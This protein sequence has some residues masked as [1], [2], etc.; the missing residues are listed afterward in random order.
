MVYIRADGNNSIGM[1]HIRRCITF[2]KNMFPDEKVLFLSADE[3]A[4]KIVYENG[5]RTIVLETDYRNMDGEIDKLKTLFD[6]RGE[7][8]S[9]E[10]KKKRNIVLVDSYF[11]TKKYVEFLYD[12]AYVILVD[13]NNERTYKCDELLNYAIY[14]DE[15][16]YEKKYTDTK[17]LLG[18]KYAP[19]REEFKKAGP[20]EIKENIKNVLITTGG[21]D[22]LHV[23]NN[24]ILGLNS[25]KDKIQD[26]EFHFLI[27]PMCE[28]GYAKVIEKN[29]KMVGINWKT[30]ENVENM[31]ELFK[32]MDIAISS[33]GST[34]Y[35]LAYMGIPTIM[36]LYANNQKKNID[37]F[38]KKCGMLYGA[39][40]SPLGGYPVGYMKESL[41]KIRDKKLRQDMSDKMKALYK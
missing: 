4:E 39:E 22:S 29:A 19:I 34:L 40:C 36:L 31:A 37:A 35:E 23:E 12:N 9:L 11:I 17:L 1:G 5:F 25:I 6:D 18:I 8:I 28:E 41:S 13:D 32:D 21:G 3:S 7:N 24:I 33:A 14:A 38:M 10:E 15:L 20:I 30:H 27:G 26:L 16:G 2:A